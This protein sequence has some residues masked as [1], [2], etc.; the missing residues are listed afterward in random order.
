MYL[1]K[2]IG[3]WSTKTIGRYYGGR[4]H[5]TVC[6]G[7]QRIESLRE[8]EPDVDALTSSRSFRIDLECPQAIANRAIASA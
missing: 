7:I 1:A 6:Y 2:H 8:S 5:S 4:D 3:K